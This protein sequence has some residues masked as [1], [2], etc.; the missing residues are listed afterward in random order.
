MA[1]LSSTIALISASAASQRYISKELTPARSSKF[2]SRRLRPRDS[3]FLSSM[4]RRA[5]CPFIDGSALQSD[6]SAS[7]GDSA[8]TNLMSRHSTRMR[9][10]DNA[11]TRIR[12]CRR[13]ALAMSLLPVANGDVTVVRVWR[14][15]LFRTVGVR[16]EARLLVR[17]QCN[18]AFRHNCEWT[19]SHTLPRAAAT[20]LSLI[21]ALF[22][23]TRLTKR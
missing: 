16:V 22:G 9:G 12:I 6:A 5:C 7:G 1:C 10:S 13:L 15:Q 19:I 11:R 14:T 3:T 4:P 23:I 20:I 18:P 2:R 8:R 21:L 17:R